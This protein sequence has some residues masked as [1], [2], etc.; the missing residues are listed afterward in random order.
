MRIGQPA[1]MR[2][3]AFNAQTTP[4]L[5]GKV[6]HIAAD[7]TTDERTGISYYKV[8]VEVS[9]KEMARLGSLKLVPG[10]PVETFIQTGER[11]LLSYLTKPL[12]DQFSRAFREN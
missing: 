9:P 11:S 8:T 10:M 3:S 1:T 5:N 7:R 2:F 6:T 4:E 12:R